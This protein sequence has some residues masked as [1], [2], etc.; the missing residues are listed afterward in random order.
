MQLG[1]I[2][3][4]KD[5]YDFISM[6]IEYKYIEKLI[7]IYGTNTS[8]QVAHTYYGN[9]EQ[10]M[11]YIYG[12]FCK[13]IDHKY[14]YATFDFAGISTIELHIPTIYTELY[15]NSFKNSI[16]HLEYMMI[17]SVNHEED[18]IIIGRRWSRD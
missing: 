17:N 4:Y 6:S 7:Y 14:K 13:L 3:I 11:N 1:R 10:I 18:E 5:V 9:I 12:L 2:R 8:L 15:E 16:H